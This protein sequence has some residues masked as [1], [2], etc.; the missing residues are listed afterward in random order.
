MPIHERPG[1]L[2]QRHDLAREQ[3]LVQELDVEG[4]RQPLAP[5]RGGNGFD[6]PLDVADVVGVP[7]DIQVAP[8][9]AKALFEGRPL[10]RCRRDRAAGSGRGR[11]GMAEEVA[12]AVLF[13]A[14]P[15]SAYITGQVIGVNGG[16]YM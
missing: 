1:L 13:L 2:G 16:L 7:V 10:R 6:G 15:E 9:D 4:G 14:R 12:D 5:H 11:L 3:R 8:A